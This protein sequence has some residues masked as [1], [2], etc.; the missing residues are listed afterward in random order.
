MYF[1]GRRG[2]S[3]VSQTARKCA[4][5]SPTYGRPGTKAAIQHPYICATLNTGFGVPTSSDTHVRAHQENSAVTKRAAISFAVLL[6][7]ALIGGLFWWQGQRG[8][9]SVQQRQ[10]VAAAS[11]PAAPVPMPMPASAPIV[12][13]PVPAVAVPD[14]AVAPGF[15]EALIELF[16]HPSVA[17]LFR[18]DD[19]AHRFVAT[20]DNLGRGSASASVWPVNPASGRFKTADTAKGE[21]VEADNAL[22]YV[23]Y[24]L[25]LE[26]VDLRKAVQVYA[27]HYPALQREYEELGFPQRYFNDRFVDVL[28]QLL[29]T[30]EGAPPLHVHRPAINGAQPARPWVLYEFDDPTLQSLSAGQRILLR[31]GP[32]NERRIKARLAQ[33]RRLLVADDTKE[34]P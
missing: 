28:D 8:S 5:A 18:T 7:A 12:Q 21:V 22:R 33:L 4:G 30:P 23:P 9:A 31:T 3:S 20:I 34:T 11:A 17:S 14:A 29:A 16:G 10:Q 1:H 13:H 27:Q 26:Q 2:A 15:D 24:V 6:G 19:F 32:V 25:L